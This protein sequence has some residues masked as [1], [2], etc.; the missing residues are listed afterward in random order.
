[1]LAGSSSI[2]RVESARA[3]E[4]M[5]SMVAMFASGDP[6]AAAVFV[7]EAYLDHQGSGA[8]PLRGVEGFAHV[9]RVNSAS[10]RQ[11]EVQ[12]EDIFASGDR[13]VASIRRTGGR[14]DGRHTERT[15]IDILRLSDGRAV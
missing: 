4:V 14:K 7:D 11:L 9:V 12:I 15:T 10:Y 8:G 1:V 13:V 6:S 2:G 5:E 3:V